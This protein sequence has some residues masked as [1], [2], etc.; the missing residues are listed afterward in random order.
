LHRLSAGE[1]IRENPIC[2]QGVAFGS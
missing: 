2:R 1:W